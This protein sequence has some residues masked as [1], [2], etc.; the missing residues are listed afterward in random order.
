MKHNKKG[1]FEKENNIDRFYNK[2]KKSKDNDC[3]I[4]TGWIMKNSLGYGGFYY[5]EKDTTAH[6]ASYM[7]H[8][9]DVPN[10]MCV[11]HTCDN[12]KCVN[13]DHLWLGTY[14]DNMD[15]MKRKK[16]HN[17]LKGEKVL[18]HKL[19]QSEVKVIR[20]AYKMGFSN[21]YQLS[22]LYNISQSVISEIINRK[23][24]KHVK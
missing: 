18:K 7:I 3:W 12:P 8:K 23:A 4:W 15:D 2:I 16:R 10:G 22:K 14:Q 11:C 13:P 6:R 1:R 9:G 5:K 24:W 19:K 20:F 17:C 21:Q